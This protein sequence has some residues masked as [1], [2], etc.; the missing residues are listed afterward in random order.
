[1]KQTTNNHFKLG[2]KVRVKND[3]PS[4]RRGETGTVVITRV[5][6]ESL[7]KILGYP[8]P[9]SSY[10]SAVVSF[11]PDGAKFT[12]LLFEFNELETA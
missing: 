7:N 6:P 5:S 3:V 4:C 11:P 9:D 2:D 10:C 8:E 1:M 12:E